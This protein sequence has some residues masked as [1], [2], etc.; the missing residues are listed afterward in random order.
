MVTSLLDEL[1]SGFLNN[2]TGW[3][4]AGNYSWWYFRASLLELLNG[5]QQ[6]NVEGS[7]D[8]GMITDKL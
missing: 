5:K 6:P 1:E 4:I 7:E 2:T 8:N 3:E